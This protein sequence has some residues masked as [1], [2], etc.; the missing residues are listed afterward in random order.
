[1]ITAHDPW[2]PPWL[3]A[4]RADPLMIPAP[5]IPP[6][7]EPTPPMAMAHRTDA[8]GYETSHAKE[9]LSAAIAAKAGADR[10]QHVTAVRSHITNGLEHT[11]RLVRV[12][13]LYYE[14]E[15]AE[16]NQLLR[17]MAPPRSSPAP[18]D[19]M[20]HLAQTLQYQLA[21]AS[22]HAE[23]MQAHPADFDFNADHTANHVDGAIE[24]LAKFR[25]NL[26]DSYPAEAGYLKDLKTEPMS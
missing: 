9:R 13:Q 3:A 10:S 8:I 24:H 18:G 11:H 2:N 17:L 21:H 22:R 1:M 23:A 14:P 12:M 5:A 26:I 7:K 15:G 25:Q 20:A 16:Y 6:E 19:T 4:E